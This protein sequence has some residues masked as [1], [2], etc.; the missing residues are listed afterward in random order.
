MT[1]EEKIGEHNAMQTAPV[2]NPSEG[3]IGGTMV[4][5]LQDAHYADFSS[6]PKVG[7]RNL[8]AGEVVEFPAYYATELIAA[9]MAT[10]VVEAPQGQL[11]SATLVVETPA[12]DRPVEKPKA[13]TA[14]KEV[15][16]QPAPRRGRPVR[17]P[18]EGE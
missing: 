2:K 15:G 18:V 13:A 6:Y 8:K 7:A 1:M 14:E 9:G 16:T 11:P 17:K 12:E 10:L 4:K 3:V 5:I